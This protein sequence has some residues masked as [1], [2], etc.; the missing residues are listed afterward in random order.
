MTL[1]QIQYFCM[2]A[3]LGNYSRAAEAVHISQPSLCIAIRKLEKEFGVALFQTNRKGAVLTDAGRIFLQDAQGILAQVDL[4][5][6]HMT[7]F[8]QKDRAEVRFAYTASLAQ[9]Y[10]PRLLKDFLENEG[11]D[12]S[13]YSDE[14]PTVDIARELREGHFDFGIGSQ[15]SPEPEIEEIP[16][17]YQRYCL[18]VPESEGDP[19]RF[20]ALSEFAKEPMIGYRK[21]FPMHRQLAALYEQLGVE[22][23]II[24]FAY[25]EDAI[26][27]LVEQG[28]GIAIVAE[29]EGLE[30]C[31]VRKCFP[32]WLTGG[33][34]IYLM[35]HRTRLI[36]H[37]ARQ[38]QDRIL[39]EREK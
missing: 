32:D 25:S 9:V 11:R 15:I 23:N 38:L 10:V 5:Q 17:F 34:Y 27:R 18:I 12:C 37:A 26:A 30:R 3:Q 19:D 29:I 20:R 16:L 2:A 6:T 1:D 35:R 8:A 22:P 14:M 7:Q 33:R 24:H 28:L 39:R 13:I 36:T 21:D 4:A 31:R